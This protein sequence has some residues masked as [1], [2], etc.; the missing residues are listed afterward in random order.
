MTYWDLI[1]WDSNLR[2]RWNS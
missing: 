1:L 2:N